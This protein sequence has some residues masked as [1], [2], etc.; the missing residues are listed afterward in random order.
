[1]SITLYYHPNNANSDD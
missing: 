1:M